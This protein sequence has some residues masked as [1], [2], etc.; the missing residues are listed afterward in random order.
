MVCKEV[1]H[2]F[3]HGPCHSVENLHP[4]DK[5]LIQR[6]Y[7][8]VVPKIQQ[9]QPLAMHFANQSQRRIPKLP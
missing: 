2:R 5:L 1:S 9:T 8:N 7:L 6:N 4:L 3:R